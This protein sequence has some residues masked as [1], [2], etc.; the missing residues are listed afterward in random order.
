M[1]RKGHLS[2]MLQH[3]AE[4]WHN[5]ESKEMDELGQYPIVPTLIGN[6]YC[7]VVPQTGSLLS[8]RMADTTLSR[9]THKIVIIEGQR[10]DILYILDPYLNK[11]R[12]EIF[13]EVKI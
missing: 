12:L 13:C 8:G 11:E 9:T 4:L 10:Y 3:I 5:V 7:A 6:V 1:Y 2:S